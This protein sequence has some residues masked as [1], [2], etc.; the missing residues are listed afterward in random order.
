[1]GKRME[2]VLAPLAKEGVLAGHIALDL[3]EFP[4]RKCSSRMVEVCAD[5]LGIVSMAMAG[6]RHPSRYSTPHH[7]TNWC[8]NLV[9]YPLSLAVKCTSRGTRC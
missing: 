2:E 1:M 7:P 6:H 9:D 3:A 4:I 8:S 5:R